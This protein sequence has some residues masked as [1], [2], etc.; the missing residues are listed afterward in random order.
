MTPVMPGDAGDESRR[1]AFAAEPPIETDPRAPSPTASEEAVG[2]ANASPVAPR[3]TG[4]PRSTRA[5]E[6]II[7]AVLDLLSEGV[8]FDG[9]AIEAVAARA[10]VGKATVYRRWPNK[11]ALLADAMRELKGTPAQPK[12]DTFRERILS[13]MCHIGAGDERATRIFPCLMPEV[14]RSETAYELWQNVINEPR[15]EVVRGVLRQGI[16]D[17]ELRPDINIEVAS[18]VLAGPIL[19]NRMLRWNPKVDNSILAE[20]VVDMVL[21]GISQQS[22]AVAEG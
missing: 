18:S 17:G 15:R 9:I 14:M 8:T 20:Q 16:A 5:D 2:A 19:L 12:G 22:Q 10:G 11:Q 3:T 21:A 13:L 7:E 1:P 4:R 6:A